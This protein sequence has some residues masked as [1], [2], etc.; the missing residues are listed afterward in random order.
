HH[1]TLPH[2]RPKQ[3][4]RQEPK[5]EKWIEIS[6]SAA[7]LDHLQLVVS[8]IDDVALEVDRDLKNANE[9]RP[10]L[11]RNE[12][13]LQ[14]QLGVNE[15]RKR[16]CEKQEQDRDQR[17]PEKRIASNRQ[18]DADQDQDKAD[19]RQDENCTQLSDQMCEHRKQNESRPCPDWPT[20]AC[21]QSIAACPEQ[22]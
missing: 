9:E 21:D 13:E 14:R 12:L 7:G 3:V 8:H 10:Q 19:L 20:N 5:A 22:P 11:R 4:S 16:D 2:G 17:H 18:R 6:Q 1:R 15:V